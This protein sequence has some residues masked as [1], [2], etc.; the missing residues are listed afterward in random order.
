MPTMGNAVGMGASV[1]IFVSGFSAAEFLSETGELEAEAFF[2]IDTDRIGLKRMKRAEQRR[3]AQDL[4]RL[5]LNVWFYQDANFISNPSVDEERWNQYGE[6]R[7]LK[8]VGFSILL[9][10][11]F[12]ID[13]RWDFSCRGRLTSNQRGP[14]LSIFKNAPLAR[15]DS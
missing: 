4:F 7:S 8:R 11:V 5:E 6:W 15:S 9:S 3:T 2:R 10:F 1:G 14:G 13:L 12:R